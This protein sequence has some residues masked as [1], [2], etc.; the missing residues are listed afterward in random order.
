VTGYCCEQC[1]CAV[2]RATALRWHRYVTLWVFVS[3]I[4]VN[5]AVAYTLPESWGAW[6]WLPTLF[7]WGLVTLGPVWAYRY[8]VRRRASKSAA[9]IAAY[10]NMG[11]GKL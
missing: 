6:R 3:F 11:R 8:R 5:V 2:A 1:R 7:A 9:A 4:G 10:R